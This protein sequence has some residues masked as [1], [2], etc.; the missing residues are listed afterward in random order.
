[1]KTNEKGFTILEVLLIIIVIAG[2]GLAGWYTYKN[3][4]AKKDS[5]ISQNTN[6]NQTSDESKKET[7]H[8]TE[9]SHPEG[10]IK[11]SASGVSFYHPANWDASKFKVHKV[12]VSQTVAGTNFGPYS[13]RYI[14]KTAENKWYFAFK[15]LS[16]DPEVLQ[17]PNSQ[18]AT[19]I[20]MFSRPA[21]YGHE[22]EGGGESKFVVFTDGTSSYM[23]E[24]PVVSPENDPTGVNEQN[25]AVSDLVS[26]I[27]L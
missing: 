7:G 22:G 8:E 1:M 25:Q 5:S 23:I 12:P 17:E 3:S 24:F 18:S 4:Q 26:T 21:I 16:T 20:T 19:K 10:W 11:Y 14:F 6:N 9:V 27:R 13:A 15:E 2:L